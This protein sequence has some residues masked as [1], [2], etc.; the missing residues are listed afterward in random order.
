MSSEMM[1]RRDLALKR[2]DAALA[3]SPDRT[4]SQFAA[5]MAEVAAELTAIAR[6]LDQH[7]ADAVERS[8]TWR[9][10]GDALS[11]LG[12]GQQP[13]HLKKAATA[14]DTAEKAL[15]GIDAPLARAKV[16]FNYG[17][18]IRGMSGG[19]DRA[20]LE[21]ALLRYSLAL[22][23]FE[24]FAPVH[25]PM[26]ETALKLTKSQLKVLGA[27]ESV[28]AGHKS[29]SVA[30]AAL[31]RAPDD[32]DVQRQARDLL[33]RLQRDQGAPLSAA[34]EALQDAGRSQPPTIVQALDGMIAK[35]QATGGGG[36]NP[37]HQVMQLMLG[38]LRADIESGRIN[39][40][41]Q[42]ELNAVFEQLQ[43][44]ISLPEGGAGASADRLGILQEL[45]ER[46]RPLLGSPSTGRPP[47]PAGSRAERIAPFEGALMQHLGAELNRRGLGSTERSVAIDLMKDFS[48]AQASHRA[49][50]DVETTAY[51][52][53]LLRPLAHRIE[54][55]SRRHHITIA[56]PFWTSSTTAQD[57]SAIY[58]CGGT[59]CAPLID[60]IAAS[61]R[62]KQVQPGKASEPGQERWNAIAQ[63]RVL[64]CDLRV[65]HGPALAAACYEIGL[66]KSLGKPLVIVVAPGARLPFDIEVEPVELSGA[67][68]ADKLSGAIERAF[69]VPPHSEGDTSL[70]RTIAELQR[71]YAGSG[72]LMVRK[73]LEFVGQAENDAID[74]VRRMGTLQ[75]FLGP[76]AARIIFPAWPG[77]YPQTRRLFHVM[78][79]GEPWSAKVREAAAGACTRRGVEYVRGDEVADPRIIRSIWDEIC[80]ASHVL[81]DLSGF[82][83]NVAL[84]LGLAH[85]LGRNCLVVGQR[86]TVDQLFPAIKAVRTARYDVDRMAATLVDA[87]DKFIAMGC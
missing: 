21:A 3:R 44:L 41:R 10:V 46:V 58:A 84:E 72:D 75:G 11:D 12:R 49:T 13:E 38:R 61:L 8:S 57:P 82:N 66:A 28:G 31:E 69:Y 73:S 35:L 34:I 15:E 43:R 36:T 7:G 64:L 4:G 18:T 77:R 51:E 70:P 76:N 39:R 55:F 24:R 80:H 22:P 25:V 85:G 23:V 32:P 6:Q 14:Y 83:P 67:A 2:H 37:F 20:L 45:M 30:A 79:F 60:A 74:V 48:T 19:F 68:D 56:Q 86:D 53:E 27:F 78:P 40:E 33:M 29:L 17:N 62:L 63:C 52:R 9:F 81:V 47:P 59:D 71:R 26:V 42:V 5:E 87:T 65:P 16:D 1:R 50:T 54:Q